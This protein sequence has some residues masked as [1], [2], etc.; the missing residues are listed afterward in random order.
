MILL[1]IIFLKNAGVFLVKEDNIEEV[2]NAV[3]VLLMGSVADRSLGAAKLYKEGVGNSIFMVRSYIVA[4]EILQNKGIS[5][6]G[7]TSNSKMV[8][9]NLNI[10]LDDIIIIPGDA[11]STKDEALTIYNY[12]RRVQEIDTIVIVTSKYHSFRSKII[13]K[14]VFKNL[15]VNIYSAPT[16][17]DPFKPKE[18]YKNREDAKNVLKEYL[19]LTYYFLYEQFHLKQ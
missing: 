14:K 9:L 4:N 17:Y 3:I 13:F 1:L 7:H 6:I 2:S 19:K 10:K 18:W 12:V 8:L 15:H 11:K 16:P 5:I